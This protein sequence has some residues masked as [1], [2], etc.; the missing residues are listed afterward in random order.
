MIELSDQDVAE[1]QA[2]YQR[3]L[4]KEISRAQ[5]RR[6]AENLVAL[7]AWV[8]LSDRSSSRHDD[9]P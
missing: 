9:L 4:S 6:Y 2:L 7:V 1:L 8:A 3:E 5:A